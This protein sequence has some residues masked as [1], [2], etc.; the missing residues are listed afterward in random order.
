MARRMRDKDFRDDQWARRYTGKVERINRFIDELGAKDDAGHPPYIP[1]MCGGVDA[2]ALSISRDPGPKA[3]GTKGSGF[4]SIENDDPSAERMGQFFDE[5]GIDYAEV[6]G[7]NAYPWYINSDPTTDQLLAG[8]E[9]LRDLIGL[10]PRLRVVLVHGTAAGKGWKLFLRENRNLIERRGIV[11]LS[12]YHTS[13]QA[14]QTPDR[15]ERELREA[16]IRNALTLAASV[17]RAPSCPADNSRPPSR[18]TEADT[19]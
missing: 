6:V 15:V 1:P 16:S 11:W 2:V 10:M 12:T 9:P 13:R 3:G 7:W 17:M 8:V 19:E 5:A 18:Q 4:L 14:L